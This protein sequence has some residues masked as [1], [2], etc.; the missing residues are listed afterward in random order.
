MDDE[1]R[2]SKRGTLFTEVRY[3]GAGINAETRISD[4]SLSGV[5]VDALSPA[6]VGA[7][8][9]L[10]FILPGGQRVATDGVVV[11]SQPG[12]GMGV[13]FTTLDE[14][15]ARLIQDMIDEHQ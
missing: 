1:R 7:A 12:I 2:Q 15:D 4:I 11:H 9:N 5:F 3:E 14:Q 8:V 13:T 10:S 6:P